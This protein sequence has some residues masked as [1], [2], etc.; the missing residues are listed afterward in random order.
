MRGI[1]SVT[2]VLVMCY[3]LKYIASSGS[4][5]LFIWF[6][7]LLCATQWPAILALCYTCTFYPC[8]MLQADLL[9][10]LCPTH[11]FRI[12]LILTWIWIRILGSTF[13][14]SGSGSSDPPFRNIGS[15]SSDPHLE[16]VDPDPV[17]KLIQIR[18]PIFH[19]FHK[20]IHVGQIEMLIFITAKI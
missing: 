2:L 9:Y 5:K 10:L 16:K 6:W 18:V 8:F 3:P 4:P 7:S 14:K 17:P 19:I 12:H 1:K 13:G 15:G 20:E 11:D